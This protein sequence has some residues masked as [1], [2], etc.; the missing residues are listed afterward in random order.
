LIKDKQDTSYSVFKREIHPQ[1]KAIYLQIYRENRDQI[2]VKNEEIAIKNLEVIFDTALK[3]ANKKGFDAMSLRDLSEASGL[4]MGALY[5]YISSKDELRERVLRHGVRIAFN[6]VSFEVERHEKSVDKLSSAIQTHLF[7]SESLRPWFYFSYMEARNLKKEQQKEA[8]A[9]E[10]LTET[11]F[12]QIL[13][14]GKMAGDFKLQNTGLTCALIKAVL[15][16]WYI[17]RWKYRQSGVDVDEYADF[18]I[19]F[20]LRSIQN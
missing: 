17:K 15:Q 5:S 4:S 10:R 7:L 11:I 20:I 12:A 14:E 2:K 18:V 16:D 13:E 1:I 3:L 8:M 9:N 19:D 6:V